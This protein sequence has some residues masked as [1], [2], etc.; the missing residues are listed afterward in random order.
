MKYY[1]ILNKE[2]LTQ[3]GVTYKLWLARLFILQRRMYDKNLIIK[4]EKSN[5]MS[6]ELLKEDSNYI[7]Y[8][9]DFSVALTEDELD[10]LDF[11]QLSY[12]HTHKDEI[13]FYKKKFKKS[14]KKLKKLEEYEEVVVPMVT[15]DLINQFLSQR[16]LIDEFRQQRNF[17]KSLEV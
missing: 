9:S 5:K 1:I 11:I 14:L 2:T 12:T 10:L 15:R 6:K 8:F 13:K 7:R 17:L 4:E 16:A 3:Y